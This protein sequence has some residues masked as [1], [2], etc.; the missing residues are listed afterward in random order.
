MTKVLAKSAIEAF[1]SRNSRAAFTHIKRGDVADSLRYRVDNP[2]GIYQGVAGLCGPAAL[3]YEV[4]KHRQVLWLINADIIKGLSV[5]G[6][7]SHANHFVALA[8]D[9]KPPANDTLPIKVPIF[10]CGEIM[11]IPAKGDMP[12]KDFLS[13]F[14]GYVAGRL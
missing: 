11:N 5:D 14:F 3:S 12:F 7:L 2:H 10:T 8:G 9:R 1:A 4:A 13:G 6:S